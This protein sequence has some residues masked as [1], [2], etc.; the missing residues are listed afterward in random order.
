MLSCTED[1]DHLFTMMW[2]SHLELMLIIA[3]N[4]VG[5]PFGVREG[6]AGGAFLL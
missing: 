3:R 2:S 4:T 1:F 6:E 5:Q